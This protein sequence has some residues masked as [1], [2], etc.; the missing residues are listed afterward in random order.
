MVGNH[1]LDLDNLDL[2]N[3]NLD[4]GTKKSR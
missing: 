2:D 4:I 1:S 3:Y